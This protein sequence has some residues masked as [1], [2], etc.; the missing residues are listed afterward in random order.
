MNAYAFVFAGDH[1]ANRIT[2]LA[3]LEKRKSYF[4]FGG[5]RTT[6]ATPPTP[7]RP[8]R[9]SPPTLPTRYF[10]LLLPTRVFTLLIQQIT[11][12]LTNKFF[13]DTL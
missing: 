10:F 4:A 11:S 13:F 5:E 8:A 1:F 12:K 7:L 2:A 6:S 9:S 3:K